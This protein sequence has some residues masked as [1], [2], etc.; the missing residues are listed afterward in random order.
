[1]ADE[2]ILYRVD[3]GVAYITISN[4]ARAN[5]LTYPMIGALAAA[6]ARAADDDVRLAVLTGSG[7]RHFC[8]GA[9]RSL[10][11]A[12]DSP[13]EPGVRHNQTALSLGFPKPVVALVNGPAVGL[14]MSLAVDCDIVV[15]VRS[16]FFADGRTAYGFAPS[17]AVALTTEIAFSEVA[18]LAL[19]GT[20]LSAERA[21]TLGIV[22]ELADDV[23]ELH[24]TA[25]PLIDQ[26]AAQPPDA[27]ARNLAMLRRLRR[28]PA[29]VD[30]LVEAERWGDEVRAAAKAAAP[31]RRATS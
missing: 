19:A 29:V 23:D 6:W 7:S 4:E 15:A 30:A 26:I 17:G 25:Q 20:P 21:F 1:M 16:A 31:D 10:V 22:T 8:A 11:Q 12:M 2:Q 18:R 27:V 5:C 3:D 28:G 13:F 9:D 24:A 14:G